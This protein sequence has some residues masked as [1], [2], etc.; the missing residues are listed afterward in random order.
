MRRF[1]RAIDFDYVRLVLG[2]SAAVFVLVYVALG[3]GR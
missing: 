1:Y 3:R 2:Y